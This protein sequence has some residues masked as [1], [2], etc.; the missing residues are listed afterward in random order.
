MFKV[1][2]VSRSMLAKCLTRDAERRLKYTRKTMSGC[3]RQ[4]NSEVPLSA[5]PLPSAD[6]KQVDEPQQKRVIMNNVEPVL[7]DFLNARTQLK[8]LD[9]IS[10]APRHPMVHPQKDQTSKHGIVQSAEKK[11]K[12][13]TQP[14]K[15]MRTKTL[16]SVAAPAKGIRRRLFWYP[17]CLQCKRR[18]ICVPPDQG[19]NIQERQ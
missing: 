4:E 11:Q 16:C 5:R 3:R 13:Q 19:I 7:D 15:Y 1:T 9:Y 2:K 18:S 17:V 14:P 12:I 10:Y 6:L 8:T